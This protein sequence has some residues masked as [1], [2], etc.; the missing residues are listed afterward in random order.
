M[1]TVTVSLSVST[2]M[3]RLWP[4][5]AWLAFVRIDRRLS[6]VWLCYPWLERASF[7]GW[8]LDV[9]LSPRTWRVW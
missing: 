3:V 5:F 8:R 2:R 9:V 6:A 1:S 4:L 7:E